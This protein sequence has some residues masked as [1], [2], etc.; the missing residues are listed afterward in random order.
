MNTIAHVGE[1]HAFLQYRDGVLRKQ[2][3]IANDNPNKNISAF[4]T[5]GGR[6]SRSS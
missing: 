2:E 1:P 3:D 6:G 4:M 5:V